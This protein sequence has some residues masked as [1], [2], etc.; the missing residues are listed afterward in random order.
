VNR[1]KRNHPHDEQIE[2]SLGKIKFAC[3]LHAYAFYI[4]SSTCRRSRY[5]KYGSVADVEGLIE[6][7]KSETS[8]TFL[9]ELVRILVQ[10]GLGLLGENASRV[11]AMAWEPPSLRL[12][13]TRE[14]QRNFDI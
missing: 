14:F 8:S 2:G 9:R 4:Y 11:D 7:A 12:R 5:Q 3:G 13:Q 1:A 6:T 10:F